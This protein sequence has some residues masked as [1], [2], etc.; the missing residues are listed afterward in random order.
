[1]KTKWNAND[2]N[3]KIELGYQNAKVT[4]SKLD[5]L[6]QFMPFTGKKTTVFRVSMLFTVG[7]HD[8]YGIIE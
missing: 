1:M 8:G 3:R 5:H 2:E 6:H 4:L 7:M